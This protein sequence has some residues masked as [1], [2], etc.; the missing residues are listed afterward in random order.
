MPKTKMCGNLL[1]YE[2]S[3][4]PGA[5]ICRISY[6]QLQEYSAL[7][8]SGHFR[9][10]KTAS[11]PSAE[12]GDNK[13]VDHHAF[14]AGRRHEFLERH[15]FFKLAWNVTGSKYNCKRIKT[16]PTRPA[17]VSS[18]GD[19]MRFIS[20]SFLVFLGMIFIAD[21]VSA[22]DREQKQEFER[23]VGERKGQHRIRQ[24]RHLIDLALGNGNLLEGRQ[25]RRISAVSLVEQLRQLGRLF[26]RP[27]RRCK[28]GTEQQGKNYRWDFHSLF[29][30]AVK[31]GTVP[32]RRKATGTVPR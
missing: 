3:D 31:E 29:S 16:A 32:D 28:N 25:Q 5:G 26:R 17:K 24:R 30:Q 23:I 22:L 27:G 2:K 4:P 9:L 8:T 7:T 19:A 21:P 12:A 13:L 10:I 6:S 18:T 20:L 11:A 14:R 1:T 15:V